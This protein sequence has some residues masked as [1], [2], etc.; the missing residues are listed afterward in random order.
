MTVN[1]LLN[2]LHTAE[3]LKDTTRH[4]Y[5]SKGRH[6]S[7]AE[8]TF[9][10]S[11]MAYFMK[12]EFPEANIDKVIK[13]CLIH[14]IGEAFT[15]DIPAFDKTSADEETE[16]KLLFDWVDDLPT[17]YNTE[18]MAL[19][20]E[21]EEQQTLEAKLF[22]ALDGLEAVIQ[23]NEAALSTWSDNEYEINLTYAE[24]K[25]EF[26]PYLRNLRSVIKEETID[27]INKG[28]DTIAKDVEKV[29]DSH[30]QPLSKSSNISYRILSKTKRN[31]ITIVTIFISIISL[32]ILTWT[33]VETHKT[34]RITVYPDLRI[35]DNPITIYWDKSGEL[36]HLS[37]SMENDYTV[38]G[39]LIIPSIDII[40][41][42]T[43][44]MVVILIGMAFAVIAALAIS[45]SHNNYN[46]S[47]KLMNHTDEYYQASNKAYEKI[48]AADW[49]DQ[50]FTIE[51]NDS[52]LLNVK[53][54]SGKI[55]S[56]KVE[57]VLGWEADSTQP[58]ITIDD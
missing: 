25:C 2:V 27:K 37:H 30:K 22:K 38:D 52:Q 3:K 18:M 33:A 16:R 13:M 45:S 19:Y 20:R 15:G 26:S 29:C 8:H 14:D 47:Q 9:R 41:I 23:H 54:L 43:S 42:G 12:D 24:N 10:L 48:A 58:V 6:E 31:V 53:V 40:N 55:T 49:A 4:S 57:N 5:T 11:L 1:D 28:N 21:M 35:N 50:E 46:L 39:T 34:N 7:V 56:W 36:V 51:I 32:F 17:P 44:L